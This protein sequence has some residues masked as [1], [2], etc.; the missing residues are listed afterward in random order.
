MKKLKIKKATRKDIKE[1]GKLMLEEF[2]KPPFNERVSLNSVIKSLN[3][4][5][6]I[7]KIYIAVESKEIIGVVNFCIEQYWEGSVIIIED[8]AVKEEFKKKGIGKSLMEF[9]EEFARKNKIGAIYFSTNK[10]S[11]AVRFYEKLGYKV[12]KDTI[13]MGKKLK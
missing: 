12:E 10:K 1:I 5:F 13:F 2:S 11:K 4:D 9:V 8:L 6:K 3:Y 7:G